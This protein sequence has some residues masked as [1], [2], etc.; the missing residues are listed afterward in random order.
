MNARSIQIRRAAA[1]LT[2]AGLATAGAFAVTG[3]DGTTST[4][5][6]PPGAEAAELHAHNAVDT[7]DDRRLVGF[8]DNV[9]FGHVAAKTGETAELSVPETQFEVRVLE[10]VKGG[11]AGTITV[12]QF[13]G[14]KDGRLV[15]MEGDQLLEPGQTYLLATRSRPE[16]GWET[17][18]ATHGAIKV[19]DDEQRR[20]LRGRFMAA[21]DRQ[22]PF[23]PGD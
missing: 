22:V 12:N 8:A 13:G 17:M 11:V 16:K 2:V 1:V 5:A 21:R 14:V 9:F 18:V 3:D 4:R 15:R 20:Q 23:K 7:S 19:R 10:V 6:T